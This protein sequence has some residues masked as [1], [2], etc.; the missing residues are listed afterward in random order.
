MMILF[1][2]SEYPFN[3][4]YPHL[5]GEIASKISRQTPVGK[6][7][8]FRTRCLSVERSALLPGDCCCGLTLECEGY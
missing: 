8:V 2:N 3:S 5:T 1:F 7:S 4:Q 6:C